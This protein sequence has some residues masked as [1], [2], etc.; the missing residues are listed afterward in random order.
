MSPQDITDWFA[1]T[2]SRSRSNDEQKEA[3]FQE[4][5]V[6]KFTSSCPQLEREGFELWR[7]Y[8]PLTK[9]TRREAN[10]FHPEDRQVILF[11]ATFQGRGASL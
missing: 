9:W 3:R 10:V 2:S 4:L 11:S 1:V 7:A 6:E 8:L 5:L